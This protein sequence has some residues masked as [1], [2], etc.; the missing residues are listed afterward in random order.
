MT[1]NT[2]KAGPAA[3]PVTT[4]ITLLFITS[5]TVMS[6]A[7]IAPS[8]P[9]IADNF[10]GQP[11]VDI[12]SRLVLTAPAIAIALLATSA[13]VVVDAV[14]RR[15][16][17]IV[18]AL[19]YAVAGSS[20]LW[21]DGLW[22]LIVGRIAL[23]LAVAILMTTATTLI[24]EMF[25]GSARERFGGIQG[26]FLAIGGVVFITLGG[27]L[28]AWHWR[29]PFAVYLVALVAI[30]A[31][32]AFVREPEGAAKAR[33][34]DKANSGAILPTRFVVGVAGLATIFAVLFYMM[35]VQL[36]FLLNQL[37]VDN[38]FHIGLV[39]AA[40]TLSGA[41]A[42]LGFGRLK[43]RADFPAILTGAF[44]AMALGYEVIALAPNA[45]WAA[46]GASVAGI[47]VGLI[48]PSMNVW[49]LARVPGPVRGRAIGTL[50]AAI[51]L[52]Q[53]LS[54][55]VAQ[56]GIALLGLDGTYALAGAI[57]LAVGAT[58]AASNGVTPRRAVESG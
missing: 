51:F 34:D 23:G 27:V 50:T 20:G 1:S 22:A 3:P 44:L 11:M 49:V 31:V 29:A 58:V 46:A 39:I 12:L 55:L 40:G 53:F 14:G 33:R 48:F 18:G 35:P 15:L 41:A 8:L 5:L 52:G 19:L 36:P 21:L 47:G 56:P 43:A 45:W 10:A 4:R 42:S 13:G 26:A 6:G 30:P 25:D 28:A 37:G 17:L 57:A 54:P 9:A 32:L 7:T 38:E 16:L 24:G 2:A